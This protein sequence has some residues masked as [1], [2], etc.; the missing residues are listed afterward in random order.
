M[1]F[2]TNFLISMNYFKRTSLK[3]FQIIA[4]SIQIFH[5]MLPAKGGKKIQGS[6]ISCIHPFQ[7]VLDVITCITSAS[8]R[9]TLFVLFFCF[10]MLASYKLCDDQNSHS[11]FL[12]TSTRYPRM[13]LCFEIKEHMAGIEWLHFSTNQLTV[14]LCFFE[15]GSLNNNEFSNTIVVIR[16]SMKSLYEVIYYQ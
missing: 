3:I 4:R 12:V 1:Y 10:L 11:A 13:K 5:R 9:Q 2:S 15:H 14:V 16:I 8:L 7:I 6:I